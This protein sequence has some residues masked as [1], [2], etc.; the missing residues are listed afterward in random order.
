MDRNKAISGI[1]LASGIAV[2]ICVLYFVLSYAGQT[3]NAITNFVATNDFTKLKDCGVTFPD[4][5]DKVKSDL[6]TV[7]LPFIYLGLP[8]IFIIVSS[9][10]FFGGRYYQRA[11]QEEDREKEKPKA[12]ELFT[13]DEDKPQKNDTKKKASQ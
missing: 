2:I 12:I 4:Q 8:L 11:R 1:L 7:I 10:M 5:F 3:M 6:S 9:L 13:E